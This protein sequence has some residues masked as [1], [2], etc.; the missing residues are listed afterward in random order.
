MSNAVDGHLMYNVV[1]MVN[2]D[3]GYTVLHTWKLLIEEILNVFT[4]HTKTHN[5]VKWLKY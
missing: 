1:M 3:D 5:Y 2:D 4:A